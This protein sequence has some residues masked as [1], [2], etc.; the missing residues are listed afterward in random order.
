MNERQRDLFLYQWSRRRAPG[1]ARIALRGAVLGAIGGLVF[2][3]ILLQDGAR[4]PGVPDSDTAGRIRSALRLLGL[5]VPA[6]AFL[7]WLLARRV[8]NANEAMYQALLA[9][10]ARVPDAKPALTFADRG[11]MLAVAVAA[12]LIAAFV[13]GLF[14][15]ASTGRL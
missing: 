9:G 1:G 14:W 8:W 6:F 10:G 5:S 12:A 4:M 7:G 15:A 2:A 3:A 13:A 11:P